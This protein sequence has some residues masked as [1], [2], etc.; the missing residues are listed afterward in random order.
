MSVPGW[1][2]R[3]LIV[4]ASL[5]ETFVPGIDGPVI[6]RRAAIAFSLSLDA[7]QVR[8][9]RWV[10]RALDSRAVVGLLHGRVGRFPDLDRA[11]REAVLRSWAGSRVPQR[12]AAF[13]AVRKLL[14]SLALSVPD[15]SARNPFWTA[16]D[17]RR[18][19]PPRTTEPT[20]IVPSVLP[21][22]GEEAGGSGPIVLEADAVVVGS[23][24]GGGVVAAGL[25]TAGRSVVVLE[26][27]PFVDETDMPRDELTAFDRLYLAHG[28][29]A[30][31][32]GSVTLV[33]GAA[34]GGGTLVNWMTT[35]PAGEAVRAEWAT[36]H[37]LVDVIG[38]AWDDDVATLRAE[39]EVSEATSLPPKD[40]AIVRGAAVLGW[41]TTRMPRDGSGC[42]DCGSCPF[43]CVRG[44]K[45][46]G[47][48]AHL[49][50]AAVGG[51][52]IVPEASVRRVLR[53]DG[54]AVGVEA[55][56]GLDAWRRARLEGGP[57]SPPRRLVVRAPVVVVAAG[58]LRTP[59]VLAR[60]GLE[61]PAIG[62]HLRI[63]PV[64]VVIGRFSERIEMWRG[65]MQAA[66]LTEFE[67]AA[68]GR[69]GYAVESAPGHPGLA[70]VALPWTSGEAF[71]EQA[72]GLA[73]LAPFI[74]VTRDGGAGR[75]RPTRRG[76]VRIDYRLDDRG[77]ATIR[78]ALDAMARLAR[79]AGAVEVTIPTTVPSTLDAATLA[80]DGRYATRLAA[81]RTIDLGPNRIGL[82]SA[83]Q[84]G[85]ARAGVDPRRHACGPGG[86][87]RT[88]TR[89]D[90]V[91]PGLYVADGSLFPTG[92]GINPMLTI[93]ALARGVTRTILADG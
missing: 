25:A 85:T 58:A 44:T 21:T 33:A 79:A 50:T 18:D 3:D 81:L 5:A 61:H 41:A 2:A 20:P 54:R 53:E 4:L 62:D 12:R 89:D 52:R 55:I 16:I 69:S 14:T 70:A 65:I 83:H 92:L 48:R 84:M 73:H 64:P 15:A 42:D 78:H 82:F 74:A 22:G 56:V 7:D 88:G 37:G 13:S 9:L 39:L 40:A 67:A 49:A 57:A 76:G 27:G 77:R 91:V 86:R 75:V 59:I 45:R 30:T 51:A 31:W 34:V 19:D 90:R 1:R 38:P 46:S 47:L 6:A 35:L 24:A 87:V 23:G 43:G 71:V 32:D 10:L 72:R 36:E 26:A 8:Q 66:R 80:D 29:S 28:L 60:S 11:G 93:M 68:D 17:Y 63:H